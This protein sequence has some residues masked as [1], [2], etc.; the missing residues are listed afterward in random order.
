VEP[1]LRASATGL[2]LSF[3]FVVGSL[4]PTVLGWMKTRVG[5]ASGLSSLAWCYLFGAVCIGIAIKFFL[6]RDYVVPS[7]GDGHV[8]KSK[9][10]NS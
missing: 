3:A 4:A 9:D 6:R 7:V 2:M 1:R 8:W 10:T 5:L